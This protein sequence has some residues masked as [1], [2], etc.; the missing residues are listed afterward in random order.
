MPEGDTIYKLARVLEEDLVGENIEE[1]FLRANFER[2]SVAALFRC[3]F[4]PPV[5]NELPIYI[6]SAPKRSFAELWPEI[7]RLEGRRERMLR[8]QQSE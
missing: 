2:V 8:V 5:V 6:A 3:T 7:G 4:C 1:A